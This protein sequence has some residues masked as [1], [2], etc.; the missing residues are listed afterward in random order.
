MFERKEKENNSYY[1]SFFYT[2]LNIPDDPHY[3]GRYPLDERTEAFFLHEYI[4]Y[5]QDLTTISGYARIETIVDQVKWVVSD[6]SGKKNIKIPYNPDAYWAYS[7]KPNAACL[8]VSKGE[9]KK[10]TNANADVKYGS[11]KDFKLEDERVPIKNGKYIRVRVNATFVF[12][13][14]EHNEYKYKIGEMAISESMAYIIEN[15]IYPG[16]LACGTDFPYNVVRNVVRWK[17]PKAEDDY[18]LVAICDVSLMYAFPGLAFYHI[19]DFLEIYEGEVTPTLIYLYG[20]GGDMCRKLGTIFWKEQLDDKNRQTIKQ[21]NDYFN[22]PYWNDT[23]HALTAALV[24]AYAY[25]KDKPTFFLDIMRGGKIHKNYVFQESLS[26]MG[27]MAVHTAQDQLFY[28]APRYADNI[29]VDPDWFVSLYQLY[30][31]LFTNEA[32]EEYRGNKFIKWKCYL[33]NWCH[34]S[35]VKKHLPDITSTSYNCILSPWMNTTNQLMA[36]CAFGRL[37]AAYDLKRV[38]LKLNNN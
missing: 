35:F 9:M 2:F 8:R 28:F 26:Y 33:K 22:H 5:L 30:L 7:M 32:I 19:V 23:Q 1:P 17:C 10:K 18:I 31:I 14:V 3:L 12:E 24:N 11:P 6:A 29:K 21:L 34:E 37:W 36:Q 38:K 20:L 15:H 27:C 16:V 4:H 25:R 13:D